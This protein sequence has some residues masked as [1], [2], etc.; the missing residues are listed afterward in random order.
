MFVVDAAEAGLEEVDER[1]LQQTQL[2]T[3]DLH[4]A[5]IS[6]G[7]LA[8]PLHRDRR[9]DRRGQN[10][11]RRAARHAARRDGRAGGNGESVPRRF[12]RRPPRR[13]A[14]GAALLPAQS[15]SPAD[16]AA[17]GRSV[18]PDDDL[19]LRVR[20]GQDLRLPESRRQRAVHLP[21]ALRSARARRAAARSRHLPAGADRRAAA[22]RPQPRAWTPKRSRSS[23]T[24]STC[25]S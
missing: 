25:G 17:P 12:L 16:G 1:E 15:P 10:R 2:Q 7:R 9:T 18:Q 19:R 14:A 24:T 6:S 21:A 23:P 8:V 22:P 13:R 4:G 3:F 5:M 20:Q 11:A